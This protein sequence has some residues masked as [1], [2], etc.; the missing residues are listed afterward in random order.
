VERINTNLSVANDTDQDLFIA[1]LDIYGFESLEKNRYGLL[2]LLLLLLLLFCFA[3]LFLFSFN[4]S[5]FRDSSL[6]SISRASLE[7]LCINYANEKLHEQFTRQA[8]KVEQEEYEKQGVPWT[9][10][11]FRDNQRMIGGC[12]VLFCFVFY[13]EKER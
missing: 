3:L 7:Q 12:F 13:R 2:L 1:V 6:S 10:I 4:C 8:F 9:K 11:T 5:L